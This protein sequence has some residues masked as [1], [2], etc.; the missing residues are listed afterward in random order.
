M[1]IIST[2]NL[3]TSIC[4]EDGVRF[5][6]KNHLTHWWRNKGSSPALCG[7][8]ICLYKQKTKEE[9]TGEDEQTKRWKCPLIVYNCLSPFDFVKGIIVILN[10]K[11]EIVSNRWQLFVTDKPLSGH[12][13]QKP[14]PNSNS[15]P[16]CC[17]VAKCGGRRVAF[18]YICRIYIYIYIYSYGDYSIE[19]FV[20]TY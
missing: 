9:K 4:R 15:P 3:G 10:K 2:K 12:F 8:L 6:V 11:T 1:A 17:H 5:W 20:Y 16:W 14:L 18:L 19:F 7:V 13:C